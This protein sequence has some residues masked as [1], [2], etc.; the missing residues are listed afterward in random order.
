M[1]DLLNLIKPRVVTLGDIHGNLSVIY[2]FI[3]RFAIN[4]AIVIQ[5]G[6]FGYGF[7]NQQLVELNNY[8]VKT[9]NYLVINRGN[10]DNP[11]NHCLDI[12]CINSKREYLDYFSNLIF[13][14]DYTQLT[15]NK[16]NYLFIGGATSIDRKKRVLD[17][18][19]WKEEKI[20]YKLEDLDK[21]LSKIDIIV[22]HTAPT[23]FSPQVLNSNCYHY[24]DKD[25][26]LTKELE[27]ERSYLQ[28][29]LDYIKPKY[30][31]HGH[32]HISNRYKVKDTLVISLGA[33]EFYELNI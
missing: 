5:V 26:T 9:K 21:W 12:N 1:I 27:L 14:E 24:I 25:P 32:F 23:I 22:S 6:D 2:S 7:T 13:L 29:V 31:I 8:L 11:N 18:S 17:V 30:W 16:M 19:Y 33:D 28:N 4:N 20:V 10:H 15:I 3:K